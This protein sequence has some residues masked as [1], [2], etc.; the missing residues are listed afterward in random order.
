[1]NHTYKNHMNTCTGPFEH[2]PSIPG[3]RKRPRPFLSLFSPLPRTL[4]SFSI[5]LSHHPPRPLSV[6]HNP[7]IPGERKR[8]LATGARIE[9]WRPQGRD[10]EGP[11]RVWLPGGRA[12]GLTMSRAF[13]DE[14]GAQLGVICEVRDG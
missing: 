10:F 14:L 6:E 13:G 12:P 2:T 4:S 8:L 3:E 11:E 5:P 7:S 1:M 9:P